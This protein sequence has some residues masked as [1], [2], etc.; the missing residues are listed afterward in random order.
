MTKSL[1]KVR[2]S[3]TLTTRTIRQIIIRNLI[4]P[5]CVGVYRH[6]KLASQQIR[7]NLELTIT[8]PQGSINDEIKNVVNYEDIVLSI[9]EVLAQGHLNLVET[10]AELIMD[11]CF[12]D[13]RVEGIRLKIEK[14]HAI[15][16]AES[17]GVTIEKFRSEH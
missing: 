14:L 12:V 16:E 9:K 17:V 8:D 15:P 1:P 10:L 5:A 4:L 6:E 13:E 7:I 3:Q 2:S 11:L